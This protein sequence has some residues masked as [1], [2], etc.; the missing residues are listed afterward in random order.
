[1]SSTLFFLCCMKSGQ[2]FSIQVGFLFWV[3]SKN[4]SHSIE[5]RLQMGGGLVLTQRVCEIFI[6][7]VLRMGSKRQKIESHRLVLSSSSP[8][9]FLVSNNVIKEPFHVLFLRTSRFILSFFYFHTSFACLPIR[10]SE[11][12][13]LNAHEE[14][15]Q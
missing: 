4:S 13:L 15:I 5:S 8:A 12:E 10:Q 9:S 1:M 2:D 6:L 7:E 11:F 3:A 14:I